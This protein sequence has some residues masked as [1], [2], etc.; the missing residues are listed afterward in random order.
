MAELKLID[1]L[2]KQIRLTISFPISVSSLT[3]TGFSI[4]ATYILKV[5]FRVLLISMKMNIVS[6]TMKKLLECTFTIFR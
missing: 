1:G 2:S 5:S 4:S 3:G 6:G